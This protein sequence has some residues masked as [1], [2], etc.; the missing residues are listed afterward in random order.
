MKTLAFDIYGTL[1]DTQG[2]SLAL[3][4]VIG[5]QAAL[6]SQMWR[7]KQLE[8]SF[9]RGLMRNYQDFARCTRDALE[10]CNLNLAT[11][12]S[13]QQKQN[14]LKDYSAL[15]AFD[16]VKAGLEMLSTDEFRLF[17]FSN[18]SQNAVQALLSNA[19]IADYFIDII[20]VDEI[21]SFKPDPDVYRHFLKRAGTQA[22]DSWL[23]SSNAF[24]VTGAVSAGMNAVWLQRIPEM[25]FDQWDIQPTLTV[26][27]MYD[28]RDTLK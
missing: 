16:D 23:I 1:I 20:S 10:F 8:Y 13:E 21:K 2:I 27:S 22:K 28:L 6:F 17:A 24:D 19:G 7:D 25:V 9:R 11:Q 4:N 15:P 3:Q 18:G 5:K 14:L 26:N 12:L